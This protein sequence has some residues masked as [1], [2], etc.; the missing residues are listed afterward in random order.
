MSEPA[1]DGPNPAFATL[2]AASRE[3]AD[4]FLEQQTH[5]ARLQVAREAREEKL[6]G[7]AQFVEYASAVMKLAF[8]FVVALIVIAVAVAL[9]AAVWSASHDNGLVV[10]AFSVPPDLEQRGLTGEVVAGKVLDRLSDLQAQTNSNR[11]SASYVN[12]WGNDIKVQ[13]PE[14]GVSIGQFYRYL[15]AWLGN[16]THISGEIYRDAQGLAVTARVAGA[17]A[18]TVHGADAALDTLIRQAAEAVYKS[19]QPYRYAVYL[20]AHNRVPEAQAIYQSLLNGG[21]LEDRAW[22]YI[23]LASEHAA[24][25][26][27]AGGDVL[28]KRAIAIK[29]DVL[30]PY[31]NLANNEGTLQHDEQALFWLRQALALEARGR[32]TSMAMADFT[33]HEL[34]DQSSLVQSFGDFLAAQRVNGQILALPDRSSWENARDNDLGLCA[35]LHDAVCFDAL[36]AA[37][38]QTHDSNAALN[39][40]F[41]SQL[42][43][44]LLG[45]SSEA[46][47]L[48][49]EIVPMLSKLGPV[50]AIFITRNENTIVATA[51]AERGDFKSAQALVDAMPMDCA[52]CLR[53]R[54]RVAMLRGDRRAAEAWF[55]RAA[56]FAPSI[57]QVFT[58]WG[59]MRLRLGDPGGAIAKLAIANQQGPRFAD[60]LEMWGEALIAQ[61]RSDLALAKFTEAA[62]NA[63]NWGRLHLKWG[64]ALLWSGDKAGAQAQ[65]AIAATLDLS[66]ADKMML[67]HVRAGHG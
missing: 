34:Q 56:A 1:A 40:L 63:P 4:A 32:D 37:L 46:L 10:E 8:E 18:A 20:D 61:N 17:P 47:A 16:E 29:P 24:T 6:R 31:D 62:R 43:E 54:G 59:E 51:D 66:P 3:R 7:W 67:A 50:A 48:G 28:L 19:T 15:A 12:N 23:G 25:G 14:T 52:V 58:D 33:V 38:P 26:D 21:A 55:V 53:V 65:F 36:L 11:A 45:R 35:A 42:G 60:P 9:G 30:L 13:I 39:R 57:P 64:E 27:F 5:L 2:A 44:V 49:D 22:A 41:N